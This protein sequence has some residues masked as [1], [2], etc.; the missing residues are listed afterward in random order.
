MKHAMLSRFLSDYG[1]LFVLLLLCAY[2]SWAT[3]DEQHPAGA[4]GAQQL[5]A[6]I[7]RQFPKGARVVI[8]AR[9]H[10]E[11]AAFADALRDRL[12]AAGYSVVDTLKGQPADARRAL[13]KLADERRPLDVIA[14]NQTTATWAVFDQL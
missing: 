13:Q 4:A 8:V 7:T 12:V 10:R 14:C 2:Y 1:M 6:K 9:D 3:C 11:D 5:A